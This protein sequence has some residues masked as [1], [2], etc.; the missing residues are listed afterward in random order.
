[1]KIKNVPRCQ[2]CGA[3]TDHVA[4]WNGKPVALCAS[5]SAKI[6]QAATGGAK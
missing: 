6:R 4:V 5:C 1:M 3:E 2:Q